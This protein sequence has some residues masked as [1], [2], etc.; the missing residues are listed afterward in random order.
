MDWEGNKTK[1]LCDFLDMFPSQGVSHLKLEFRSS[2][3][4]T[5]KREIVRSTS[6]QIHQNMRLR[7][8]LS[9]VHIPCLIDIMQVLR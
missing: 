5:L 6:M 4:E 8:I 3:L 2:T 7:S 1:L 9:K